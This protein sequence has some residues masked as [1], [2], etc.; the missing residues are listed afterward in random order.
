M[1]AVALAD[2]TRLPC[3]DMLGVGVSA[4]TM[5]QAVDIID[6]WIAQRRQH[7]VCV[8]GVHGLMEARRDVLLRQVYRDAGLVTADGMPLVWLSRRRGFRDAERVYGPDLMLR[9]CGQSLGKGYR[10]YF[11]GATPAVT[12]ELERRLRRRFT[13]LNVVGACSP[14]FRPL[15]AEEDGRI[16]EEINATAPD[17]VWVG[18]STPKQEHWMGTHVGR[19]S[20]PALIGVGAAFDFHAGTKRQAPRWMQRS[21]L[22]W[23][24]RLASEPKRLWRRYLLNNPLFIGLMI[25][26]ELVRQ[27]SPVL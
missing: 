21:G 26:Q 10:H 13:G 5:T 18:L 22:E 12:T 3:I 4:V 19:V 6:S 27:R 9:M 1:R 17:V 20:A 2:S 14:P 7:Y 11:Y 23:L 16:V 25:S 8:T 24:Y 15:T